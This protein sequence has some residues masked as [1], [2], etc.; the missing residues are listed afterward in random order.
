MHISWQSEAGWAKLTR[1]FRPSPL[2][3]GLETSPFRDAL[4]LPNNLIITLISISRFL[5]SQQE[6]LR[7]G[8]TDASSDSGTRQETSHR[9]SL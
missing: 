9:T 3:S 7:T 6:V 8:G 2:E 1:R 5:G 4:H